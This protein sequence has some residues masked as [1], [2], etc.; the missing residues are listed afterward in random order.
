V[1]ATCGSCGRDGEEVRAVRRVYV[2][3]DSWDAA[4]STT[5]MDEIEW[6]CFPCCTQYPHELV[7]A[8]PRD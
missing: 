2:T 8:E 1:R 7:E 6:W 4:G 3:P 5:V